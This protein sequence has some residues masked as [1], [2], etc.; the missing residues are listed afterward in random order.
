MADNTHAHAQTTQLVAKAIDTLPAALCLYSVDLEAP[1]SDIL[2]A[3][4]ACI[5]H[6]VDT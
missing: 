1:S 6:L 4:Y 2:N 3:E 5:S